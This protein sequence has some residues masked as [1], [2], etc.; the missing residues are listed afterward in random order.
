MFCQRRSTVGS[1]RKVENRCEVVRRELTTSTNTVAYAAPPPSLLRAG[2]NHP[3]ITPKLTACTFTQL[4]YLNL[5]NLWINECFQLRTRPSGNH[6]VNGAG[7]LS[8]S[9]CFYSSLLF[10]C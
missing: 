10:C 7:V 4:S 2:K 5:R 6:N 8:S 1:T 3:Q 9:C